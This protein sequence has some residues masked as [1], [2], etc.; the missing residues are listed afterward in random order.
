MAC[1]V[2]LV[3]LSVNSFE[4]EQSTTQIAI[5]LLGNSLFETLTTCVTLLLSDLGQDCADLVFGG[6]SDSDEQGTTSNRSNDIARTVGQK[7]QA[8]VGAVF[9]HCSS[10]SS[11]SVSG[12]MVGLVDDDNLEALLGCHIDLLR[13]SNLLE[14][15]LYDNT[16][17]VAY[18]ARCYLEMVVGRHDVELEFAVARCLEDSTV[19]LYLFHTRTVECAESSCDSCFFA[20]AGRSIDQKMREVSALCL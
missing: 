20:R 3:L 8:Q 1:S 2:G 5:A 4:H 10:Q 9:L 15:V 19:D 7:N 6:C 17:I 13:L 16:V 12:E 18:I 11:L 14:K